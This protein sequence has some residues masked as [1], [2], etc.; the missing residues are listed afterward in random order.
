[1]ATIAPAPLSSQAGTRAGNK[2]EIPDIYVILGAM[3]LLVAL[4][5]YI[6]PAGEYQ[7]EIINGRATVVAGFLQFYRAEPGWVYAGD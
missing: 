4:L 2:F 1:M 3:I 7:R 6:I 5:S